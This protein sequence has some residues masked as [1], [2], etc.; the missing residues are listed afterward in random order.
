MLTA[1]IVQPAI[2][3]P[4]VV[5]ASA[6][7]GIAE[8]LRSAAIQRMSADDVRARAASLASALDKAIATIALV[9]AGV[10]PRRN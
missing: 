7:L 3:L 2:F 1:A 8:P 10:T 5:V 6:L 4:A 9:V